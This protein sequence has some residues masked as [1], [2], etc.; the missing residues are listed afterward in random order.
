MI[1]ILFMINIDDLQCIEKD[2]LALLFLNLRQYL[3]NENFSLTIK[4]F[5]KIFMHIFFVYFVILKF[6]LDKITN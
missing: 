2:L 3:D 5:F 4:E 6:A 1:E